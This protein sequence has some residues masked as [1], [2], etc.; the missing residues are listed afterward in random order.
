MRN[1]GADASDRDATMCFM[2]SV[3]CVA[4]NQRLRGWQKE[5]HL[6]FEG[7]LEAIC[8][9]AMLKGLPT[10]DEIRAARCSDAGTYMAMLLKKDEARF[11]QLQKERACAF[12]DVP[13]TQPV[14]RCI[15]HVLFIIIRKVEG[16]DDGGGGS[17]QLTERECLEW[18]K[19]MAKPKPKGK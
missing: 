11:F 9:L 19:C 13:T 10:D 17:V 15:E 3:M 5:R 8:R 12:G 4:N 7:F 6:P 1:K 18:L 2:W 16:S 14:A